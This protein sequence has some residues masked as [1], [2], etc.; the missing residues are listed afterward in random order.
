MTYYC[1]KKTYTV[2]P[3]FEIHCTVCLLAGP[4]SPRVCTVCCALRAHSAPCPACAFLLCPACAAH[5]PTE[6]AAL[7]RLNGGRESS[8]ATVGG[9]DLYNVVLPVRFALLRHQD[10]DM[11]EWL[12]QYMDHSAARHAANPALG[13]STQ[14]MAALVAACVPAVT[15]AEAVRIIGV[16]FTNCF[17]LSL[18]AMRARALYPLVSLIN[19]SCVPNLLH[20]NLIQEVQVGGPLSF[21]CEIVFMVCFQQPNEHSQ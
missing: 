21:L 17:E 4:S 16:L 11:Y 2:L 20:T 3:F 5:N 13:R 14:R 10:P 7:A 15:P 19:H 6:C 12:S 1:A 18:G 8:S 9:G